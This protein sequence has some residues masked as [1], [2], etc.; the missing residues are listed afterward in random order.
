[1]VRHNRFLHIKTQKLEAT[2]NRK[3]SISGFCFLNRFMQRYSRQLIRK[4]T[5]DNNKNQVDNFSIHGHSI[6][7]VYNIPMSAINRPIPSILDREKVEGMKKAMQ[8]EERKDD[9]TP[10]V[11]LIFKKDVNY[12]FIL[13]IL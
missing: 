11:S 10:I 4:M 5:T 8:T 1:M 12:D 7:E 9:L 3:K 2:K 13:F 6:D